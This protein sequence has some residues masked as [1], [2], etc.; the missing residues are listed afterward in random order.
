MNILSILALVVLQL[1]FLVSA[2]NENLWTRFSGSRVKRSIRPQTIPQMRVGKSLSMRMN[3]TVLNLNSDQVDGSVVMTLPLPTGELVTFKFYSTDVMAPALAAKFPEIRS[4][5]GRSTNFTRPLQ[6]DIDYSPSGGL[7][8]YIF[9]GNAQYYVDPFELQDEEYKVY[10]GLEFNEAVASMEKQSWSCDTES[11][12]TVNA[13]AA[14]VDLPKNA[15]L[16]N[17][18]SLSEAEGLPQYAKR[19]Y[20]TLALIANGQ[21]SR[22]HGNTVPGVLAE[23]VT[24]VNR[25]NGV[26]KRSLGI[27]FQLHDETDLL[28]CLHP[29]PQLRN[30]ASVKTQ[31]INFIASKGIVASSFDFG[32]SFTTNSGGSSC[33]SCVCSLNPIKKAESTTGQHTPTGD[34]FFVDYVAHEIGHQFG[35]MHT[36]SD[37][38]SGGYFHRIE[39]G[40]GTTVMGYAGLCSSRD[41]QEAADPLFHARSLEDIYDYLDIIDEREDC[42]HVSKTTIPIPVTTVPTECKVPIGSYFQLG[43]LNPESNG[44]FS[45]EQASN[46][47]FASYFNQQ[48]P[49]FRSWMPTR[50]S[51]RTFP[52]QFYLIHNLTGKVYDEIVPMDKRNMTFRGTTRSIYE[53]DAEIT[54]SDLDIGF[55]SSS[56]K[57]V[58]VVFEG[59][60]LTM[61]T[62]FNDW[63]AIVEAV[64][65]LRWTGGFDGDKLAVYIAEHN[66]SM[67]LNG[68]TPGS[69]ILD[70]EKQAMSL[71]WVKI[72]EIYNDAEPKITLP[73]SSLGK[74]SLG[75]SGEDYF[76]VMLRSMGSE[77]CFYFDILPFV[78][79][80][81]SIV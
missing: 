60:R 79:F 38:G 13:S 46:I 27:M 59:E 64:D 4:L 21:Y 18:R 23:M 68:F 29:C 37:C 17:S 33:S 2:N 52:N 20:Y 34:K 62:G 15:K 31:N 65:E 51:Y 80:R 58:N 53:K 16:R 48:E 35:A 45:Y 12:D 71:K 24:A 67:A 72:T 44:F 30:D 56:Y 50:G 78:K 61:G 10:S 1:V 3:T 9:D 70:Y 32:H 41:V 54:D 25:V 81:Q 55:G 40:S 57:D 14:Q 26:Y 7:R 75:K 43:F 19:R 63:N 47:S 5:S 76:H 11:H 6:A 69:D 49:R 74:S 28:I 8:A 42:G 66:A 77:L 73:K 39:P 22:Y 36:M